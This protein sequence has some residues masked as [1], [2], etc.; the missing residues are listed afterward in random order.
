MTSCR[1]QNLPA[2]RRRLQK[3]ASFAGRQ[4]AGEK[5]DSDPLDKDLDQTTRLIEAE[6]AKIGH[7][8]H[9][10]LLP[11]IFAAS[12]AVSSVSDQV[13]SDDT[14][15]RLEQA[16]E[17]LREAL[18]FGRRLLTEIYPAE[19][20][21][22][23]WTAAAADTL[24]RLFDNSDAQI[25]WQV[26]PQVNETSPAVAATAYRIVIE[27]VRNAIGHGKAS[28]VTIAAQPHSG[29]IEVV[30]DDNGG[31]FDPSQVASDRFGIRSMTGRAQL[32]GGSLS[33]ESHPGGPTK[34]VFS[35]A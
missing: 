6:R 8:I 2:A 23:E 17:W 12:S 22:T 16:T 1:R 28:R 29:G 30:I 13:E 35:A 3:T 5:D 34:V 19:L 33:I 27:A 18:Q 10:G 20:A 9:D 26:D 7:E 11:L 21:G 25:Q 32:V 4:A 14:R 15:Q 31:G 24:E